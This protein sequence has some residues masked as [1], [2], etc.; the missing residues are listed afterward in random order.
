VGATISPFKSY[1]YYWQA[2]FVNSLH[3]YNG[4]T[5]TTEA[6][7]QNANGVRQLQRTTTS[8]ENSNINWE[9]PV[10]MRY[11]INNF[12]GIGA[13]LQA[14]FNVSEKQEQN[15]KI[16]TFEGITDKLLISTSNKSN[17]S[18]ESFASFKTGLLLDLTIGA[19]RIGP[20]FGA[21][22]VLNFEDNFNYFQF[23]GIWKF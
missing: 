10:L 2:E 16:E 9:I 4:T 18:K 6:L 5:T 19:A 22:Y 8:S 3:S 14:N 1:R 15:L 13:G 12:I 20:S 17:T 21:R 7:I 11:N 23:Y